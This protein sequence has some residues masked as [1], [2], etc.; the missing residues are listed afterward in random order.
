MKRAFALVVGMIAIGFVVSTVFIGSNPLAAGTSAF[1]KNGIT[2]SYPASWRVWDTLMPTSGFGSTMAILGTQPWGP[3][4]PIDQNCH[5]QERLEPGQISV[6]ISL[7]T[8]PGP[9]ICEIG[10]DRSDLAGRGPGDP[11]ATGT[12]TR[13]DGRPTLQTDY[14]VNQLDYYRSDEWRAWAI[15]APGTTFGRYIVEAKYR[16]PGVVDFRADLDRLVDSIRF[17]G[18]AILGGGGGPI[19]CGAPFPEAGP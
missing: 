1:A 19:D 12:L 7:G 2:F 17:G 11:V 18:P 15:A 16:G 4:L 8:L 6:S 5:Y 9:S 13:V 3:C 14:A 10:V